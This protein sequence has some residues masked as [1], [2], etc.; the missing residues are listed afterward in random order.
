MY[1]ELSLYAIF[2]QLKGTAQHVGSQVKWA[3]FRQK[4]YQ[5]EEDFRQEVYQCGKLVGN[6]LMMLETI[7]VAGHI[8]D[9]AAVDEAVQDGGGDGGV[10]KE[11]CP[12]VEALVGGD[13]EGSFFAHSRDKTEEE[14][15]LR[16]R[17]GHEAHLIDDHKGSFVKEL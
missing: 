8:D 15:G 12:L 4:V 11:V 3:N 13:D 1:L 17:E 9:L 6:R 2:C 5:K 10:A 16:G 7:A 14:I